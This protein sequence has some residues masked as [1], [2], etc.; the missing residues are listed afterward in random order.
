MKPPVFEY[1]CPQTIDE[2]LELLAQYGAEA[3]ILAGG[4]SLVPMLNMRLAHPRVVVDINRV[5]G[6]D[7]V[8]VE[9][10]AL[11][12]GALVRHAD[13]EGSSVAQ[14]YCPM[15]PAAER[16]VG[17]LAIRQRGTVVGSVVHADPAAEMPLV[18]MTLGGRLVVRSTAGTRELAPEELYLG[19][20]MTALAP[21]ELAVAVRFELPRA[22]H[23]WAIE[24]VAR[25]AGD[26]AL[27]AAAAVVELDA[28]RGVVARVRLG[29]GGV[30]GAPVRLDA[31]VAPLVGTVGEAA[32]VADV[33]AGVGQYLDPAD[34]LHA[35]RA[36]RLHLARV[37]TE[38]ALGAAIRRAR[39]EEAA[40]A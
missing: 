15:L 27:C 6:L 10:G 20:F 40:E 33:A 11:V 8:T 21:E 39:G 26:F 38:R 1:Y 3:K 7:R 32:A 12:V 34:D 36:F 35:S 29:L 17:H 9:D 24:E 18:W 19:Y 14:A 30:G 37:L 22:G 4:Q 2:A 25:R 23:G 28:A 16:R 31:A 5:E 13:L